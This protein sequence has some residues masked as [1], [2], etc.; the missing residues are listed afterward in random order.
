[1]SSVT[2]LAFALLF[3]AA[4][5]TA[6]STSTAQ[7]GIGRTDLSRNDLSDGR[8][9]LQ[10]LVAFGPGAAAAPHSHPGEELVYVVDGSIEYRIEGRPSV[11][12]EGG[13]TLFIPTGAV[14]SA[15]NVGSG[16]AAELAT[17]IVA[18]GEPLVVSAR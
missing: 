14:H 4:P 16:R 18:K 17:Y 2:A 9:A 7:P 1:M 15:R 8:E 6:T 5:A 3:A 10:V 12:L 13:D 11:T